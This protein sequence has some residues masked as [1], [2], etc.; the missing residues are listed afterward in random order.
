MMIRSWN[1]ERLY[2]KMWLDYISISSFVALKLHFE[3]VCFHSL[4]SSRRKADGFFKHEWSPFG[5]QGETNAVL[6][7]HVAYVTDL[8]QEVGNTRLTWSVILSKLPLVVCRRNTDVSKGEGEQTLQLSSCLVS[9]PHTFVFVAKIRV[10]ILGI[11]T[12]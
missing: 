12:C 6:T 5:L 4:R 7:M 3:F 2:I 11:G 9:Q 1:K 8:C 10:M